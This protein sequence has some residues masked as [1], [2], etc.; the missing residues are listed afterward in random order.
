MPGTLAPTLSV[1]ASAAEVLLG[2]HLTR[3][4]AG[5]EGRLLVLGGGLAAAALDRLVRVPAVRAID[6]VA[7]SPT[8]RHLLA[9]FGTDGEVPVR[10]HPGWSRAGVQRHAVDTAVSAFGLVAADDPGALLAAVATLLAPDGRLRFLE[11]APA[12]G[13]ARHL[14]HALAP[15]WAA[16]VGSR[17]P[18]PT[19]AWRPDVDVPATIRRAGLTITDIERSTMPTLVAPLRHVALGVARRCLTERIR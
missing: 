1:G 7:A 6:V 10:I 2:E 13:L 12:R 8:D 4:V 17:R 15:L 19:V 3:L 11:P 9:R 16:A 5:A 18:S 14:E